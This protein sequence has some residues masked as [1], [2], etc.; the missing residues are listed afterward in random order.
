MKTRLIS[1]SP[2]PAPYLLIYFAG[3]GTPPTA[4]SHL[5]LPENH[6]LLICYDYQ[7]L[8]LDFDFSPYQQI[9][10]VAF[11][12]GVWV[13]NQ[14]MKNRTLA[15]AT[16]I[17]GTLRPCDAQFGIP[18]EILKGTLDGLNETNRLKFERRMCQDL[19]L[20]QQYQSLEERRSTPELK[21]ELTALYQAIA[22]RP[23]HSDIQWNQAMIASKDFIF[24]TAH[25]LSYWQ[26]HAPHTRIQTIEGAHYIFPYFDSWEHLCKQ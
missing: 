7:N 12:L 18:P 15:S 6:D 2:T 11:S 1:L 5:K 14:L 22:T 8:Q 24:P 21:Q 10:L 25:Q 17:N 13:A 23:H 4:V 20:Y 9:R 19:S 3:W 16:A 26:T